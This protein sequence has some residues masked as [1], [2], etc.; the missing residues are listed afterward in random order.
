MKKI[1]HYFKR[2]PMV[3]LQKTIGNGITAIPFEE[4]FYIHQR[5]EYLLKKAAEDARNKRLAIRREVNS[6]P[7]SETT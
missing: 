4:A 5:V 2:R 1:P 3:A 7:N 6:S